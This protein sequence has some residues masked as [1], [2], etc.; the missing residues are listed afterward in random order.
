MLSGLLK[1]EIAVE[2]SIRI[3]EA[4]VE[5]RKFISSNGQI[6]ERLTISTLDMTCRSIIKYFY[7]RR[8]M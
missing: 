8:K 6:F 7:I 2:V 5:I 4:F 3:V 1:N